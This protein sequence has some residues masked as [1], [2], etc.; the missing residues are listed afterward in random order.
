MGASFRADVTNIR[1]IAPMGR[2]YKGDTCA[3]AR[4]GA[5]AT[6]KKGRAVRGLSG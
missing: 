2:S 4:L 6:R 3:G 5:A 1:G